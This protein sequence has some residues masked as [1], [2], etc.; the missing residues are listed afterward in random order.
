M[1]A[2]TQWDPRSDGADCDACPLRDCGPPV[3]S[4][5]RYG[6]PMLLAEAP[7]QVEAS[8]GRPLCGP[9]GVELARGLGTLGIRRTD[10]SLGNVLACMPPSANLTATMAKSAK[11]QAHARKLGLQPGDDG[12]PKSAIECCAP[13]LKRD[14]DNAATLNFI[15]L[16]KHATAAL[17]PGF[18]TGILNVRG[19]LL[20]QGEVKVAPTIH[21]AF[22]LRQQRWRHVFLRDLRR[23][24]DWFRGV[25]EWREPA[26][27]FVPDVAT[28]RAF[29]YGGSRFYSYDVETA[30]NRWALVPML[31]ELLCIGFA[32]ATGDVAMCVPFV[33]LDGFTR[34]YDAATETEIRALIANWLADPTIRKVGHNCVYT[35]TPVLCAD[36]TSRPIEQLVRER[37]AGDVLALVDGCVVPSRVTNWYR[38]TQQDQRWVVIRRVGEKRHARGLTVTPDH[39]VYTVRGALPAAHLVPGDAI[40]TEEYALSPDERDALLGTLLGDSSASA[41]TSRSGRDNVDGVPIKVA[42]NI[43][44]ASAAQLAGGH[45]NDALVAEKIAWFGGHVLRAGP[46]RALT[47][48]FARAGSHFYAY[49]TVRMR[50]IADVARMAYDGATNAR[51]VTQATL[52]SIGPVGLAWWFADDGCKHVRRDT[53]GGRREPVSIA[54]CR[55]SRDDV[56]RVRA[57]FT[58]RF[59]KCT[60]TGRQ[61]LWLSADASEVFS[62]YIAPYLLPAARY[63]LPSH[64]AWPEFRGFPSRTHTPY[65]APIASVED[66]IPPT[67][68]ASERGNAR[69][70]WCLQTTAGNF[71]TGFGLVR[72]CGQYDRLVCE[73][74]FGVTPANV[75]DTL[76]VDKVIAPE[77]PHS[78]GFVGSFYTNVHA[79]KADHKLASGR[80]RKNAADTRTDRVEHTYNLFDCS[81]SARVAPPMVAAAMA[82]KQA[83]GAIGATDVDKLRNCDRS[84]LDRDHAMQVVGV[85][86]HRVG[87]LV[88]QERRSVWDTRLRAEILEWTAAC[89]HLLRVA[90]VAIDAHAAE[91]EIWGHA[92][93]SDD[94]ESD[95]VGL[96]QAEYDADDDAG[97]CDATEARDLGIADGFNPGSPAQC[98]AVLFGQWN[99]PAPLDVQEKDLYTAAGTMRTSAPVLQAL[100][101]DKR[102]LPEQRRVI[103]AIRMFRAF[104]KC[105]SAYVARTLPLYTGSVLNDRSILLHDGRIHASWRT[106]PIGRFASSPNVQNFPYKFDNRNMK[107]MLIPAPGHVY[108]AAD[109][110]GFHLRIIANVWKIP[111]LLECF[112][113]GWDAH[114]VFAET[115]SPEYRQAQGYNG[116]GVKPDK[117]SRANQMRDVAKRERFAGAYGAQPETQFRVLRSDEDQHGKSSNP[118]LKIEH[119][120]AMHEKWMAAEPEWQAAWST[121][122]AE[123]KRDGYLLSPLLKRRFDF[124]DQKENDMTNFPILSC[125]GDIMGGITC[126]LYLALLEAGLI[127]PN[128]GL[129]LLNQCHDS[130]TIECEVGQAERVRDMLMDHMNLTVAGWAV[131][132]TAEACIGDRYSVV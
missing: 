8:E 5:L 101:V 41:S 117:G 94:D 75:L 100:M 83:V 122:L 107:E 105:H 24:W 73:R 124:L 59:G 89:R 18:D 44:D 67:T 111:S 119:V 38:T 121:H 9:S 130:I 4:E 86:M 106:I 61:L 123:F 3:R 88:D 109:M 97:D 46:P 99:L 45:T 87:M 50:Q 55:Y 1:S 98:G 13:R 26:M 126:R 42:R 48:S 28:L 36:G 43:H 120:Y 82:R 91:M 56:D 116:F 72:N 102:V 25:L 77:M 69:T 2:A 7:G 93:R 78:L 113:K 15:P 85:S 114:G 51:C 47:N 125:E 68:N 131:P 62:E 79:W 16:G 76:L 74:A 20:S 118:G 33:G 110:E 115:I 60:I 17:I 112:A 49:T 6:K 52:D 23:S 108:V 22:V 14:I 11:I 29:L 58:V 80:G 53:D 35:G 70:R 71:F 65:A 30:K 19:T 31:A 132:F 12:W 63:K 54:L 103:H 64:R 96:S 21:P 92:L 40:L 39:I 66:W 104:K 10:V 57:W 129:G 34:F 127:D 37:Y 90:G 81:V 84:P 27:T 95:D 128:R 32:D